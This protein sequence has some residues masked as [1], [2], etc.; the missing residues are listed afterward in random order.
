MLSLAQG[1]DASDQVALHAKYGPVVRVAPNKLSYAAGAQAHKDIYGH[2]KHGQPSIAKDPSFYVASPNG[3]HNLVSADDANHARQRKA[4]S[5]AFA[6]KT[7]KDLEPLLGHWMNKMKEKLQQ[8]AEAGEKVDILKY[9]NCTTFDIMG[10]LAFSEDL[11]MLENGEYSAWVQAIF[12]SAKEMAKL[13]AFKMI[14]WF[15]EWLV[16]TL[17]LNNP[18][19]QLK[20]S[21][22]W[23]DS[24]ERAD[25]RLASTPER[26][27][28]WTKIFE[29]SKVAEDGLTLDEYHSTAS[30]LMIAGTETTATA[31]SG[32]MYY[33]LRHPQYFQALSQEIRSAHSTADDI[34]MES[35]QHL[36][37]LHAVLQE[38]LRMY[39]PLPSI[40]PRIA[41]EGLIV[42]GQVVPQG[43]ILG[44]SH[45]ATYRSSEHFKNASEFRPERWLGEDV[46][47]QDDHRDSFEPFAVGPRNCLGKSLAWHEMRLVLATAIF[48][49]DF[50]LCEES[51]EWDEQKV[52]VFWEKKA[53]MC[54][55]TPVIREA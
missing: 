53:L 18:N 16:N 10:D 25:R 41:P 38:G 13:R 43:T 20:R 33:L 42:C 55:L 7:L 52:Y 28:L 50:V 23:N 11:H 36:K 2:R 54:K 45:L 35:L 5:P 3:V 22:Y 31:L 29:K 9:F 32:V 51:F 47:Y 14:N 19:A 26:P 39:P 46:Q 48:H 27:D 49:F 44:V 37:Y 6:D 24:K 4:L 40:L 12:S 17:L 21:Q 15:T 34:T 1:N 8:K 30:I